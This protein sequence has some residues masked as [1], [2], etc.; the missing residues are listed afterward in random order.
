MLAI[1]AAVAALHCPHNAVCAPPHCLPVCPPGAHQWGD[2]RREGDQDRRDRDD[3]D[4]DRG[5][6]GPGWGP[7]WGGDP[8]DWRW[9][10]GWNGDR[11]WWGDRGGWGQRDWWFRCHDRWGRW[12]WND[13]RCRRYWRDRFR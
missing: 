9:G 13:W 8:G 11:S 6:G 1:L 12:I 3:H 4:R 10:G 7:G 5:R 2:D